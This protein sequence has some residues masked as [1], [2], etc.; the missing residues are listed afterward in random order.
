MYMEIFEKAV[1]SISISK[2]IVGWNYF[3][4]VDSKIHETVLIDAN[5][6]EPHN[7]VIIFKYF[8]GFFNQ[9]A[10]ME[11]DVDVNI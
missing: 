5:N 10:Y 3:F 8:A 9:V 2:F 4:L 11:I 1:S 7:Y 6:K